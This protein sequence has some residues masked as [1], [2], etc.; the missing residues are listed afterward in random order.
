MKIKFLKKWLTGYSVCIIALLVLACALRFY[1]NNWDGGHHLHPDE[2]MLHMVSGNINFFSNLNPDFFNYGT[3]PLY[4]L[5]GIAQLIDKIFSSDV[6]SYDGLLHLGRIISTLLDMGV[7]VLVIFISRLLFNDKRI[8]VYAAL[9]YA[10]SFFAIQN[11]NFFIV[12]VFVN[13][14]FSSLFFVLLRNIKD[15]SIKNIIALGIIT[16][17]LLATKATPVILLPI[18]LLSVFIRLINNKINIREC[19]R[20]SVLSALLFICVL[21]IFHFIFMPYAYLNYS[22][23]IGATL[24]QM[25]MGRDAY[26]FPYTLQYVG[27]PAYLYYLKN[28]FFWGMGPIISLFGISGLFM[29]LIKQE[30]GGDKKLKILQLIYL[31]SNIYFFLL[32]G[33]TAVKFMRYMLPLYPFFSVMAGYGLHRVLGL[34][35]FNRTFPKA[36]VCILLISAVVWTCSFVSIFSRNHTRVQATNWILENVPEGSALALEHWDEAVPLFGLEKYKHIEMPLFEL[37]DDDK[38]WAMINSR[39]SEADYI[40]ISSN[41]LYVPLQRLDDCNKYKKCYPKASRYY[42]DLFSGKLGFE[43]IAEFTSYPKIPSLPKSFEFLDDTADES[44]SV[45]DHPKVMIFKKPSL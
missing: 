27:T 30:N 7:L 22:R 2:R 17:A 41:K 6:S 36:I 18:I 13:F 39:L 23:F 5:K 44:F 40:I 29:L 19:F 35:L 31:L 34:R 14:L 11:S 24:V 21:F 26:I 9:F 10:I 28:I 16:A 4:M 38:K 25:K 37:P 12:D 3:L 42:K 15:F 1:G 45:Y 43:M 8:A 33:A 32:V 20:Q